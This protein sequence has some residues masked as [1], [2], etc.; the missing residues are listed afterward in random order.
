MNGRL[1][2]LNVDSLFLFGSS[3]TLW[4]RNVQRQ[5]SPI[6]IHFSWLFPVLFH[7]AAIRMRDD[8]INHETAHGKAVIYASVHYTVIRIVKQM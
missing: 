3:F 8:D 5:I 2:L 7:P 4:F 1:L 6:V